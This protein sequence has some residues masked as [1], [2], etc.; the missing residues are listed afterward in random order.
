MPISDLATCNTLFICMIIFQWDWQYYVEYS[1]IFIKQKDDNSFWMHEQLRARINVG[2]L[3]VNAG[4]NN[5][6]E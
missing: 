3:Y 2:P 1:P 6:H 5:R 4:I